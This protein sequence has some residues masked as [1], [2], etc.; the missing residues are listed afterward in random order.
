M[1]GPPVGIE[2]A[3]L[4]VGNG[5]KSGGY[6]ELNSYEKNY[7]SSDVCMPLAIATEAPKVVILSFRQLQLQRIA[8]LQDKLCAFRDCKIDEET[9]Q[10]EVDDY[11]RRYGN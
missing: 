6:A 2:S 9:R 8:S 4:E 10:A 1:A 3:D 5:F 11:L 7:I